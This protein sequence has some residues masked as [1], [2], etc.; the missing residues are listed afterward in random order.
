[1]SQELNEITAIY[2]SLASLLKRIELL[3]KR[4]SKLEQESKE[5]D[6]LIERLNK[7]NDYLMK[8]NIDLT[9]NPNRWRY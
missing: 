8:E 1:M 3:Y 2:Q 4:V 5:K 7:E 6:E 9:I